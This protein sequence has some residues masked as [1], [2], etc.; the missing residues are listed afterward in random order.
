MTA[1]LARIETQHAAPAA[2]GT[3]V[4]FP[5]PAAAASLYPG[6][7]MH[8]RMKPV[9]HRFTYRVFNLLI[10]IDRLDEA[11]RLSPVFSVN[12]RNLVA[13]HEADHTGED[14]LTLRAYV[15]GMLAEAGLPAPA[16]RVLL[17]CYP[18]ILGKVFNPI[19]VYY[20][21]DEGDRLLALI[22][23][24]RNTFGERHTYVCRI[25]PGELTAAGV[26]QERDKIFYV[27][28][29]IDMEMRYRF[30]MQPPGETMNW[31]ILETDREGPLLAATYSGRRQKLSTGSLV[32]ETL[33]VPFQTWKI[34]AGIH[35]EALR[36][37]LKGVR[38]RPRGHPP[39]AVTFADG[40]AGGAP[41]T[42]DVAGWKPN[43][44]TTGRA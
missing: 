16:A 4:L 2:E 12:R 13:F 5:P 18:R 9:G 10:D 21:Y 20:A 7:V 27:S 31:R 28:P 35:F 32:A 38:Y 19:A 36:L 25:E 29:F 11:D 37:W 43:R 24:V 1:A 8:H 39:E 41:N 26:R 15:D 22:Y 23:E 44:E 42:I 17:A 3:A 40:Q 33:R 30:R 34:V 6:T 14:H